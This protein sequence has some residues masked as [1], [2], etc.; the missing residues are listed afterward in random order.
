MTDEE[1]NKKLEAENAELKTVKIPQLE[2]K[3]ASIRGCHRVDLEKLKA[4]LEQV[5]RQKQ[6]IAELK[7]YNEKLLDGDIEKH[8]KIVELEAELTKR[9]EQIE[10]LNKDKDYFSDAWDKQIEATYKVVEELNKAKEIISKFLNAKSIEETCVAESEAEA[11][12]KE[13]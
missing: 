10:A 6:E 8:N 2:R 11:F 4:R 7:A 9:A 5:E 3:I 1:I 12:L 13:D